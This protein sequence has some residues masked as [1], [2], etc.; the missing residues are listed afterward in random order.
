AA[1]Q[2]KLKFRP[3]AAF[4]SIAGKGYG[5]LAVNRPRGSSSNTVVT[6]GER[7]MLKGYRRVRVGL[8]P[9]LEMGQ[10]LT[11]VAHYPNC[12]ALAG[13]LEYIGNDGQSRLLAMLQAFVAN[14]GDGWTYALEYVKRHL[15]QYRTTPV[16]DALPVNAH[17]AH[18]TLIR[19]L[20][21]RTADLHRP[22]AEPTSDPPFPP[23]PLPPP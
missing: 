20:A 13:V 3:T 22:L 7:L 17:E 19:T 5:Q 21:T 2:G 11:E 15:E 8:N 12:A 10:Y 6:I 23:H 9:E 16:G 1:A 4:Q 14:Q 18:L